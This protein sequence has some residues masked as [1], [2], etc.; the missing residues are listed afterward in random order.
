MMCDMEMDIAGDIMAWAF[1]RYKGIEDLT[2]EQL[3]NDY[4]NEYFRSCTMSDG[5][6][7]ME[8]IDA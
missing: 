4:W 2:N 8:I 3:V 5:Y 7:G 1:N 6:T